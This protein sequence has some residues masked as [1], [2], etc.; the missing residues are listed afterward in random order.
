VIGINFFP[1]FT[2]AGK[3]G[4]F[5]SKCMKEKKLAAQNNQFEGY[6]EE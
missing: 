5:F 1:S 2:G 6:F 3:T 4:S